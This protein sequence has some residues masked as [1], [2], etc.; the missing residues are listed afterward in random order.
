MRIGLMA[1]SHG[2]SDALRQAIRTLRSRGADQLFHLGDFCDSVHRN[3]VAE[4]LS[5]LI[6]EGILTVM[7][8]NDYQF[9][10]MVKTGWATDAGLDAQG[11]NRIL[12]QT[13]IIRQIGSVCLSHSLPYDNIRSLYEPVDD[14]TTEKAV[15]VFSN[16]AY[17]AVFCGHSHVPALFRYRSGR[18]TREAIHSE[19]PLYF[20]SEERYIVIV[21]S[22]MEGECGIYDAD[23]NRY[24]RL[25][26]QMG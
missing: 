8:N 14:G 24:E 15:S 20:E 16:T 9:Q 21:G 12:K 10:A 1:D 4:V 22:A 7:G 17:S 26:I 25:R 2:S 23:M 18:V 13:P 6:S 5:I 11:V 19:K 3:H